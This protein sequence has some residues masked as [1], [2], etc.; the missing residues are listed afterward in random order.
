MPTF[1]IL[2]ETS[3]LTQADVGAL[4]RCLRSL[5][6]QTVPPQRAREV[7]LIE[8]GEGA[9]TSL[10]PIY[11]EFPW[12]RPHRLG[13]EIGYGDMKA[14]GG[15]LGTGE[16]VVL[17]DADCS[18]APDWLASILAPFES[19]PDLN[20]VAGET[21]TP[22]EGPYGLAMALMFVFPRPSAGESL[23]PAKWYWANNVAFRRTTLDA[24]P[25]PEG[26]PLFRGQ[27]IVHGA[28][29]RAAGETIWR[30]PAARAIHE[31]PRRS[32]LLQRFFLKGQD[33]ATLPRLMPNQTDRSYV[34]GMEPGQAARLGDHFRRARTVLA[35]NPGRALQ[36]PLALPAALAAGS[37]YLLG[38]LSVPLGRAVA[39]GSRLSPGSR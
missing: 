2:I 4:R 3:N 6:S 22:V 13:E 20:I 24:I 36:L 35:E 26:L 16:I 39:P 15:R 33:A 7:L 30:Q 31:L 32:E 5:A 19:D 37:A 27:T 34:G 21:T 38:R 18:Y 14:R 12:L 8:N 17:C 28:M 9:E 23:A 29:L 1:S 25:L 11:R 10:A